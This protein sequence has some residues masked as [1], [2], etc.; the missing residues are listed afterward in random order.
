[1]VKGA[2]DDT[3]E[4]SVSSSSSSRGRSGNPG[5]INGLPVVLGKADSTNAGAKLVYQGGF[6]LRGANA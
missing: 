3:S 6:E 5:Y 2:S 4:S 1:M